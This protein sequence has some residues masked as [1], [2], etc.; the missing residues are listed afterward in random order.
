VRGPPP[1]SPCSCHN[2]CRLVKSRLAEI[3]RGELRGGGTRV[4]HKRLRRQLSHD[5]AC[6]LERL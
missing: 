3:L 5:L 1:F 2:I 4:V 6:C